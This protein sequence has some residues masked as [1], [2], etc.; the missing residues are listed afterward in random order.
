M[1]WFLAKGFGYDKLYLK[2]LLAH[3]R[4][5][6]LMQYFLA[7]LTATLAKE[8][9][10]HLNF[11][12]IDNFSYHGA[13]FFFVPAHLYIYRHNIFLLSEP[14][15]TFCCNIFL[16]LFLLTIFLKISLL[17]ILVFFI[18]LPFIFFYPFIILPFVIFVFFITQPFIIFFFY[19]VLPFSIF[20]F[21]I[22]FP[23]SIFVFFI[24]CLL[25]FLFSS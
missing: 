5:L 8:M 13:V 7:R 11:F 12:I 21:Y 3:L 20:V 22:V 4:A 14:G 24:N 17:S 10:P 19:I 15:S 25:S 16:V 9:L 2:L 23:F 6:D 1:Y 18:I